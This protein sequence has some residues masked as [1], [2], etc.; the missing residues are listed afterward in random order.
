MESKTSYTMV[1][2]SVLVLLAALIATALW[3]SVG[4][5]QKKHNIYAVY[6]HEAVTGLS[7]AAPVKFNGVQVGSVLKIKLNPLDPQQVKLLL[8][9]EEGTPVTTSTTATLVSQ[10]ITGTS[11]VGL[12][13]SSSDLTPL[14]KIPNEPYP[15]IPTKPSLFTQL[16][17]V[18]RDLTENVNSVSV[19]INK[20]LDEE[21]TR[22]VKKTLAN[23][24]K[25]TAV[26]AKNTNNIDGI[27]QNTEKLATNLAKASR[28]LPRVI[29]ELKNMAND[30]GQ[31]GQKVADTMKTGKAALEK[32]SQQTLPPATSLLHRLDSIAANLEQVSAQVR[33]NPSVIIRG[34]TEPKPGPGE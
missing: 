1:G 30:V 20:I 32:I 6:I 31:A 15:I 17:S 3:L 2:L 19:R 18:L 24:E 26:V 27:L 33:R 29:K 13:A 4:F 12:S 7:E 28:D 11:Y 23:F 21:N 34:S 25:F 5:G 16:D 22:N 14:Q 9:I 10:G 8:N